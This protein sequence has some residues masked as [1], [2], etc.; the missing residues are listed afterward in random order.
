MD[1]FA[2]LG[3]SVST[4]RQGNRRASISDVWEPLNPVPDDAPI[5]PEAHP[6][7]G[8]P[9][10]SWAYRNA[11]GQVMA[12][13][14][15]FDKPG[16]EK[17]IVP[18]TFCRRDDALEWRWKGLSVPRPLY[19]L[20]RLTAAGSAAPVL[21]CEGEKATDAGTIL[22]PDYVAM[23]WPNGSKA[24]N[25]ADWRILSHRDVVLWPDADTPGNEAMI[26]VAKHLAGIAA[27]VVRLIK[28]PA[29]VAKGWDAADALAEIQA[30]TRSHDAIL[31]LVVNASPYEMTDGADTSNPSSDR[32]TAILEGQLLASYLM[33]W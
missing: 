10:A 23:T 11:S 17:D 19:G 2:P 26:A 12:I 30:G 15:R 22:F 20:D 33:R 21:I 18:L 8:K 14:N 25:K 29:N 32:A 13:I 1:S 16:G 4:P 5:P 7:R 27:N 24:V 6:I 3:H 9:S 31:N 28:P